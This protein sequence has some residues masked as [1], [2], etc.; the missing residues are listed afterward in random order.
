M[1][2]GMYLIGCLRIGQ[3]MGDFGFRLFGF[4]EFFLE[5]SLI[6]SEMGSLYENI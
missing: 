1:Y 4:M 5:K 6:G 2:F 3:I